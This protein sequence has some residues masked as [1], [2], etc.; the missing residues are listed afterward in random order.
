MGNDSVYYIYKHVTLDT[1]EIF[2][3]GRGKKKLNKILFKS[4]YYRAYEK[5]NRTLKWKNKVAKHGYSIDIIFESSDFKEI[6]KKEN[7]LV[8]LYGRHD[9]GLG[10]L[11]NLTDGGETNTGRKFK[12][13][14]ASIEKMRITL[15][16]RKMPEGFGDSVSERM[17][18]NK[19]RIGMRPHESNIN[20]L[21]ESRI[22]KVNLYDLEGK[23]IKEF[24]SIIDV[25]KLLKIDSSTVTACL[26]D[27]Q[28]Q[29]KGYQMRYSDGTESDILPLKYKINRGRA[30]SVTNILT[31]EVRFFDNQIIASLEMKVSTRKI[32]HNLSGDSKIVEKKYIFKYE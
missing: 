8:A 10:T 11:V 1:N 13:S 4:I 26:Q 31:K 24:S 22:K 29:S 3:V 6:C 28:K 21:R 30:V 27:R 15:T 18:G 17:K 32:A 25:S 12:L 19:Y 20:K 9:L 23:F 5:G 2:Y 16:G 7:E 14:Q